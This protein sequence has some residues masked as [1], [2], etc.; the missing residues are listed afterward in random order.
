MSSDDDL[1]LQFI[2]ALV[3]IL[4][5]AEREKG[6][7]LAEEEVLEI[8]DGATCMRLPRS[9]AEA[10]AAQRG[11]DDLDPERVWEQWQSVRTQFED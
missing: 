5:N 6:S 11:Y 3:A 4:L 10:V 8:R 1:V 9:S 7:P 2:P